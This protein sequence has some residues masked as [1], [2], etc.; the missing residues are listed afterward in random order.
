[1]NRLVITIAGLAGAGSFAVAQEA[2]QAAVQECGPVVQCLTSVLPIL[3]IFLLLWLVLTFT[4]KKNRPYQKRAQEHMDRMEQKYDRII[5]L[6]EKLT[7][8]R[9]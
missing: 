1:M 8:D 5:E 2:E 7:T 6:L 4:M 9:R 3:F